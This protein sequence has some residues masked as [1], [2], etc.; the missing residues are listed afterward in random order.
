MSPLCTC[1]V[2]WMNFE[3]RVDVGVTSFYKLVDVRLDYVRLIN[4]LKN[5]S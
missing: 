3:P 2:G 1:N 5:T 4:K